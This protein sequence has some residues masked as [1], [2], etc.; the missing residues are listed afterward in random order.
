MLL[1]TWS[2]TQ[3]NVDCAYGSVLR[4][5]PLLARWP[6]RLVWTSYVFVN[7]FIAIG[8]LALLAAATHNPFV[9]PSLGPTAYLFFFS[10]LAPASNAAQCRF[11]P[12]DRPR[13][14]IRCILLWQA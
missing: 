14:W 10:P 9:F 5:A 1:T 6:S 12:C 3:M 13:Q 4:L 8:M 7:G 11:W 2:I